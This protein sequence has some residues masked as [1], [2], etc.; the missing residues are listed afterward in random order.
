MKNIKNLTQFTTKQENILKNNILKEEICFQLLSKKN[1]K[2]VSKISETR[3]KK[4]FE[5]FTSVNQY[6]F[7]YAMKKYNLSR[8]S[9]HS[10]YITAKRILNNTY[11][12]KAEC[13][14]NKFIFVDK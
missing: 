5:V 4:S 2:R 10:L 8:I 6:N 7:F 9:V 14:L 11:I 13:I 1:N 12:E 3:M